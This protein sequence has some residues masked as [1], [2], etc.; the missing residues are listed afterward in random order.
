MVVDLEQLAKALTQIPKPGLL[1]LI[2][3][4]Y[5]YLGQM[6]SHDLVP[7]T[8]PVGYPRPFAAKLNLDSIYHAFGS[9]GFPT[10]NEHPEWDLPRRRDGV[11][12]IP[13]PRNDEN[14]ILAQLHRLWQRVHES[15]VRHGATH[16]Q[17]RED[18]ILLFQA[19]V[20][21]DYLRRMLQPH[22]F[23]SCIRMGEVH[24]GFAKDGVP[25]VFSHAVFRFGHSMVRRTYTLNPDAR[26]I[27]LSKLFLAGSAIPEEFKI[28]WPEFFELDPERNPQ[29]AMGID[30]SITDLMTGVPDENHGPQNVV[31]RNLEAGRGLPAGVDYVNGLLMGDASHPRIDAALH[32]HLA[33][34]DSV[35]ALGLRGGELPLLPYILLEGELQAQRRGLGVL[36]SLI[37][38]EVICN[39]IRSASPSIFQC[40]IYRFDLVLK[41]LGCACR[42]ALERNWCAGSKNI[43]MPTIISIA[44]AV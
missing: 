22:V 33:A 28:S 14:I 19:V 38:G 25:K 31:L 43:D 12:S 21:D 40:G 18:V 39:A 41:S 37:V 1:S 34:N 42:S 35:Q 30:T 17:A 6:I 9:G 36:G 23:H 44:N 8:R 24:L 11:A 15:I 3:A 16:T 4:G 10:P 13:E 27:M 20:I 2:P 5:T 7:P 29:S 26:G 32:L